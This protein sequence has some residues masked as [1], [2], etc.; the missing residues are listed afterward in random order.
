MSPPFEIVVGNPAKIMGYVDAPE[1]EGSAFE[2][3]PPAPSRPVGEVGGAT[4]IELPVVADLR[5]R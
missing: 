2:A 3:S 4:L 5:A 1:F